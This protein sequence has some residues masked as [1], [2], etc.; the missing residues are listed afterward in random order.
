M[1]TTTLD[2]PRCGAPLDLPPRISATLE[3]PYCKNT[4][5]VPESLR[6]SPPPQAGAAPSALPAIL[7]LA[8]IRRLMLAGQK[9]EAVRLLRQSSDLSL[10]EAVQAVEALARGEPVTV[11]ASLPQEPPGIPPDLEPALRSLL[12]SRQRVEAVRLLRERLDLSLKTADTTLALLATGL[13]LSEALSRAGA[14][15]AAQAA[16]AVSTPTPAP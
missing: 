12:Q 8:E 5:V 4:I 14:Q 2:C 10:Q 3:C 1:S 15:A 7:D 9:I 16:R 6:T 11:Y 13:P